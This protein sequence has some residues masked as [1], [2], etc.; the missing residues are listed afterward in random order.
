M[1]DREGFRP[2]VGIVLVN[3][4]NEVF[5]GKRIRE[6][7]WQFPQGGIKKG[8]SP[9]QAM[10]RE[11]EEETGLKPEHV[12]IIGRTRDWLR[13]EVPKQW[14]RREWR[15]HLPRPEAD[16]VPAAPGRPRHRRL[17][18]RQ[19]ASGIRCLALELLLGAAGQCDRVQ[20]RGL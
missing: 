19:R 6:H 16:L 4:R 14:V 3:H 12:R 11:L 20:A 15:R 9:E 2:N 1:L 17:P 10:L 8:E 13:Y 5:W 18:A 7:S